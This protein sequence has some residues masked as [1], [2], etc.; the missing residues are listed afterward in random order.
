MNLGVGDR[1]YRC[2]SITTHLLHIYMLVMLVKRYQGWN[3]KRHVGLK[4]FVTGAFL[5]VR[6][7]TGLYI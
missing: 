3:I 5:G 1:N 2:K 4:D 6:A 7:G